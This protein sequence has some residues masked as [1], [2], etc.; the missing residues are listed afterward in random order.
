MRW[1][2]RNTFWQ[3]KRKKDMSMA[4][5]FRG[6]ERQA[7]RLLP[8]TQ[9]TKEE[10]MAS[11]IPPADTVVV[12]ISRQFG[13]G[14][15]E[16]GQLVAQAASLTYIDHEIIDEVAKRLGVEVHDADQQDEHTVGN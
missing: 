9:W 15:A 16:V 6:R 2:K 3:I 5:R 11:G 7:T 4:S 14:G 1:K 13:S 12:T 8:E 10:P